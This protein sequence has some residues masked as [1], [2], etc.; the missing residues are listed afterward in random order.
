MSAV[1][2]QAAPDGDVA[3]IIVTFRPEPAALCTLV[4]A[5]LRDA[6]PVLVMD[7]GGGCEA[8]GELASA[9]GVHPADLGSNRGIGAALNAGVARARAAGVRLVVFFDQDSAPEPGMIARLAQQ[10]DMLQRAG[11]RVGAVGPRFVD[12][13]SDPPLEHPFARLPHLLG[14]A[15][16]RCA[17]GESLVEADF[18]ITSGCLTSLE[19]LAEVGGMD[20]TLFVDYTD[21][22]WCFRARA[23]G[24]RL[25][26]VCGAAMCH[27][28]GHGRSRRVLGLTLL[29]YG[30]ARRYY[31]ARNA[32]RTLA[33]PHTEA[34]WKC[35][36]LL[37]LLLRS[38]LLPAAPRPSG[39]KLAREYAMLVRGVVHGM[40]RIGGPA[41]A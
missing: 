28:L 37:Q 9:P 23:R 5:L 41:P 40:R 4:A 36:I 38:L 25:F 10:F 26:G 35:R 20:E 27:E 12:R 3:A 2:R 39:A 7:N 22:E 17:A 15:Y 8:L 34:R 1:A 24:Y 19:V 32:I 21:I 16:V 30:P 18:L 6:V 31:Y 11:T 14:S 29:E 33:A 13:R